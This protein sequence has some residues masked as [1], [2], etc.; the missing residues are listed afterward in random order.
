MQQ[1]K[2]KMMLE[3]LVVRRMGAT[4]ELKQAELDDI[5]RYGAQELFSEDPPPPAAAGAA[6]GGDAAGAAAGGDAGGDAAG[7]AAGAAAAAAGGGDGA[8]AA[9]VGGSGLA[10][11]EGQ[12]CARIVYD[13]AAIERQLPSGPPACLRPGPEP[14]TGQT[15]SD[16]SEKAW[17]CSKRLSHSVQAYWYVGTHSSD[18]HPV[19]HGSRGTDCASVCGY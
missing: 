11:T 15:V 18:G 1:A 16:A 14:Q 4:T 2:K 12:R 9:A 3:H 7:D 19:A 5:L 8:A 10:E 13:H 17:T 6:A